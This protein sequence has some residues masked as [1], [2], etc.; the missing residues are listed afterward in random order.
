MPAPPYPDA[1]LPDSAVVYSPAT[2]DFS[3][4][5]TIQNASGFLASYHETIDGVEYSGAEIV[6]RVAQETSTNPRVLLVILE[7]RSGWVLG[8][9]AAGQDLRFPLLLNVPGY[10]GLYKE[11]SLIGK[12]L[13]I[14]Y[15]GWRSGELTEITFTDHTHVRLSPTLNAGSVALQYLFSR[16]LKQPDWQNTLYGQASFI[17]LYQQMFGDA[18]SRSAQFGPLLPASLQQPPL[19][20]PFQ[21]GER[22]SLTAGPHLAWNTGTPLGA[23]DFAPVT[24]E[25]PCK[26]SRAWAT[27]SASGLIVRS[28]NNMVIIDLDGDGFEQTGW[29]LFYFHIADQDHI[30]AGMRVNVDDPIGHPSCEGGNATGTHMHIARKYNGE[31]IPADGPVPFELGGWVAHAGEK[32]Y[33]GSLT[34]GDAIVRASPGGAGT[35]IIIR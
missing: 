7:S 27:A 11:L 28:A 9:P 3:I 22:W 1:L 12:L 14:G 34:K 26:V 16:L 18:W 5:E 21:P 35:S 15:Y 24:G 31:W 25:S 2:V 32:A 4:A 23:L 17:L 13:N 33:Q 29:V 6:Q 10:Q 8:Q 20:L 19:E 30:P